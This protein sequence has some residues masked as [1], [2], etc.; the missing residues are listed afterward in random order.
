MNFEYTKDSANPL[1]TVILRKGEHILLERGSMTY[2]CGNVELE[3]QLNANGK[4]GFGGAMSALGRS[5]V[6]G[7]SALI[8]KAT[9]LADGA[10]IAFAPCIPGEIRELTVNENE[11]WS[12]NNGAFL[13][14]GEGVNYEMKRQSLGKA[15]LGSG[16]LFVMSTT[17]IG[18]V[19]IY[20]C[21]DVVEIALDGTRS[22]LVD[23]ARA[24][25][26][27]SGLDYKP[28]AASGKLGVLSGEGFVNEY[29]GVG[30]ILVQTRDL[31][32]VISSVA[33]RS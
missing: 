16:G 20:A 19:L 7:E 29:S 31:K 18:S 13:A 11:K 27:S 1:V 21:G 10:T 23:N 5:M 26:W 6:S 12:I 33:V 9:G 25:A 14:C 22:V 28:R 24:L 32:S 4:T 2:Q 8:T 3:A 30:T 17:G 15:V